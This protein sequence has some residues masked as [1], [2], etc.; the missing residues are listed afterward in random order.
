[1]GSPAAWQQKLPEQERGETWEVQVRGPLQPAF[2]EM[3]K[4]LCDAQ[5]AAC[6]VDLLARDDNEHET[7]DDKLLAKW[8]QQEEQEERQGTCVH[9]CNL[10]QCTVKEVVLVGELLFCVRIV[11]TEF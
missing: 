10:S 6:R 7:N 9:W 3:A 5:Q 4:K 1:M 11:A 2:V 8:A